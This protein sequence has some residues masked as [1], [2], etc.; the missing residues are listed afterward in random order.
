MKRDP[1]KTFGRVLKELREEKGM[2]QQELGDY[3]DVDRSFI[4]R[5]ERGVGAPSIKI[6]YEICSI[7]GIKPSEFLQKVE[8]LL[9]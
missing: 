5:I 6:V 1:D 3:S 2:G 8:K 4:S 7:L 9:G